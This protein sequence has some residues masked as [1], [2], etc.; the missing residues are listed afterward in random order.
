[1]LNIAFITLILVII[2]SLLFDYINGFNDTAN[3]IATC[4][5]TRALSIRSAV[6]MAAVLNFAGAM[7]STKVATTI[8]KGIVDANIITQS[9]IL[10][11]VLAAIIWGLTTWYFR[12]PSSSSH[13]II[14]GIMGA[15]TAHAGIHSLQWLGIRKIILSLVL[16]PILG[17]FVGFT[18]M[19]IILWVFRN[20]AYH[21][22]NIGFRKLQIFSAAV[23]ALSHGTA[24]AQK[25]MGIITMALLSYGY[26]HTFNVPWMVMAACAIMMSLG[27]AF[28]GWRIIKT[29]GKDFVK[30][31][32]ADGFVVQTASSGVILAA[33]AFGLPTSTSHVLTSSILGIG[34][35]KK[36]SSIDW[37]IAY[38]I[39]LAWGLTIPAA[40][41]L[42]YLIYEVLV[43]IYL[44]IKIL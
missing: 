35:T 2:F 1:M 17:L 29:V 30:L 26:L 13:A 23:M 9:V 31:Q 14:G 6:L 33:S 24:D 37:R 42:A 16:S 3:A 25:S 40:G 43:K 27:T 4:V 20:A 34:L 8:G 38:H 32:P 39:L 44:V 7:I 19:V 22:L 21:R 11:G 18:L 10:A 15:S 5:S 12:I 36:L 41:T 28:G